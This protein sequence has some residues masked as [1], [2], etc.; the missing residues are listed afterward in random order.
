MAR[1]A[2]LRTVPGMASM[3]PGGPISQG[4]HAVVGVASTQRA[5]V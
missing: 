1:L 2:T 5:L 4:V 3:V